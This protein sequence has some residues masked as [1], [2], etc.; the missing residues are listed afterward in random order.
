[1]GPFENRFFWLY[2][3]G[4]EDGER[5]GRSDGQQAREPVIAQRRNERRR[6]IHGLTSHLAATAEPG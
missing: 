6:I 1:M 3:N 5:E 2:A 4:M